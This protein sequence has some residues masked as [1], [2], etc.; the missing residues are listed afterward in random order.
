MTF[1]TVAIIGA[2]T[3]GS[4]IAANIAQH[5]IDVRMI[6]I[7]EDSVKR[8]IATTSGF[9]DQNAE[10]GRMSEADAAAAKARPVQ[11]DAVS[12]FDDGSDDDDLSARAVIA[13]PGSSRTTSGV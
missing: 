6:D 3:M 8:S 5:G 11:G 7:S 2:G 13:P 10:K 1:K 9:Y 4:G 12:A